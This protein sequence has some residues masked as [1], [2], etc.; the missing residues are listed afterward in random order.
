MITEDAL[1][2]AIRECRE[3]RNPNA[4]TCLKMASYYILLDHLRIRQPLYPPSGGP[5]TQVKIL[6]D[7]ISKEDLVGVLDELLGSLE[8]ACP[9]LY[10]STMAKLAQMAR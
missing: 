10:D 2:D 4:N 6:A 8:G 5:Q 3:E 1:L 7:K 9:R